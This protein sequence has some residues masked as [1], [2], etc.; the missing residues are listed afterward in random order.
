MSAINAATRPTR[1]DLWRHPWRTC[2]AV[3]LIALPVALVVGFSLFQASSTFNTFLLSPDRSVQVLS[4]QKETTNA[5]VPEL[6]AEI[7]PEGTTVSPITS[8]D[9]TSVLVGDRSTS[10]WLVQFDAENPPEKAREVVDK[11]G[12]GPNEIVLSRSSA[13]ELDAQVGDTVTFLGRS[14]DGERHAT[15]AAIGPDNFDFVTAPALG[16][17]PDHTSV[18]TT[19]AINGDV[20]LTSEMEDAAAQQGLDLWG[21]ELSES[22]PAQENT[23]SPG[24]ALEAIVFFVSFA[25]V[26]IIAGLLILFLLAPVFTLAMGRNTRLYAL[27]SSQ[28]A[29][30]RHIMLAV[31]AYGFFMGV[32]GATIGLVLGLGVVWPAWTARYPDF[33]VHVPW[34]ECIIAWL[35]A[36]V[37]SVVVSIVPAWLAQ[38][39][40]LAAAIQ[41]GA[42]DRLLRFRPWMAIGPVALPLLLLL[43]FTPL[44][45]T[46]SALIVLFGMIAIAGSAPALV[47]LCSKI[48][49]RGP[50][51]LRL[52]GR[53]LTRRSMHALPTAIAIVAVSF[54][55][56]VF[57]VSTMTADAKH[58]AEEQII[59]PR[60]SALIQSETYG[61]PVKEST[62]AERAAADA[63][64]D[65]APGSIHP[66]YTYPSHGVYFWS[67]EDREV[68]DLSTEFDFECEQVDITVPVERAV[69]IDSQGRRTDESEE[70]REE[71][72]HEM[73]TSFVSNSMISDTRLIQADSSQLDLWQF[74]TEEDRQAA[75]RTLD[76]GGIVLAHNSHVGTHTEGTVTVDTFEDSSATAKSDTRSADLPIAEALPTMARD[77]VLISPQAGEALGMEPFYEGR[78]IA[79]NDVPDNTMREE[80]SDAAAQASQ[81][82]YYLAWASGP[83]EDVRFYPALGMG[84]VCLVVLA[85]IIANAATSMRQENNVFQSIGADP[86]L[87]SRVSAWQTWLVATASMLFGV[88]AGHI[89]TYVFSDNPRYL[90][91]PPP[92]ALRGQDYFVPDWWSFLAVLLVPLV[93]AALAA[94][95]NHTREGAALTARDRSESRSLT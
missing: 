17:P 64:I 41:G 10:S 72:A 40:A 88:L 81:S 45:R 2:A 58:R 4:D 3:I 7:L 74:D 47:F 12:L 63:V 24:D 93:A 33:P 14:I 69:F 30:P 55:A 53:S 34:A 65:T 84:V 32:L 92:Y 36:V 75:A 57:G 16:D 95:V 80:L 43:S 5:D 46:F 22:L 1:R 51:T 25:S 61:D 76:A 59:M 56:T 39:S 91:D 66:Y 20:Q 28:G 42:P 70:A 21:P 62:E 19:W 71:C 31:M 77:I 73:M 90:L 9:N 6:A 29:M 86:G 79:F 38:R 82:Q 49:R 13:R 27:M 37:G 83:V 15:V 50:L 87:M 78:A 11:L 48:A 8:F 60:T 67:E 23:P 18:S 44:G 85:L 54:V 26:Y 68:Y 89:G 94:A 35:V 52:A